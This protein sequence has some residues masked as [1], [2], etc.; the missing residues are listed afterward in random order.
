LL[1]PP[2]AFLKFNT[3]RIQLT[4]NHMDQSRVKRPRSPGDVEEQ[5]KAAA[6]TAS[7]ALEQ[8]SAEASQPESMLLRHEQPIKQ[9]PGVHSGFISP[10]QLSS[11]VSGQ[12]MPCKLESPEVDAVAVVRTTPS[13]SARRT[14]EQ[15]GRMAMC[16]V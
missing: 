12:Q 9:Q 4:S 14:G 15:V 6:V 16:L 1:P 7:Q 3:F 5:V 10:R 8:Q 11:T 13:N 2:R